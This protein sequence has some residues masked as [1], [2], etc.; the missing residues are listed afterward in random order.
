MGRVVLVLAATALAL[1]LASGVAL[2]VNK[3][4]TNGPDT[5]R[6]TDRADNL[7]GRAGNDFLV[8]LGGSDNLLGDRGKDVL[9]GGSER[10][11]SGGDKNLAGGPGNDAT[12]GYI[13]LTS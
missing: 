12:R 7:S 5:L 9:F 1:L 2:A 6:G 3:V 11:P 8:G 10:R 4:G 13:S